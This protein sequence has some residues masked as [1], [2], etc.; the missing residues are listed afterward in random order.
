M[1]MK[2]LMVATALLLGAAFGSAPIS[3]AEPE[4]DIGA[5][6][7][8]MAKTVRDPATCCLISGGNIS[9][10]DAN[11]CVAPAAE[12]IEEAPGRTLPPLRP[13]ANLPTLTELPLQ[14]M[15]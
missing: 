11:V 4:W 8:C 1:S 10:G 9:S 13:G 12:E 2:H 15:A 6:D 14:P 3:T 7:D 5:Y